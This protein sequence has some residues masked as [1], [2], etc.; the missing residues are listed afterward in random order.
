MM[1]QISNEQ[2]PISK[3]ILLVPECIELKNHEIKRSTKN[4]SIHLFS[5]INI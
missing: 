1:L 5:N 2:L 4:D 3:I